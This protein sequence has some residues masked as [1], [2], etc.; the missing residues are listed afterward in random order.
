MGFVLDMVTGDVSG[1]DMSKVK[2]ESSKDKLMDFD[3][4]ALEH[5]ESVSHVSI[6]PT[7]KVESN[8]IPGHLTHVDLE[9]F[10]DDVEGIS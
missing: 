7:S 3:C 8:L 4:P 10:L 5:S 2:H 9:K 6:C 1:E